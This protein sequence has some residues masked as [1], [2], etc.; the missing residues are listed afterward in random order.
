MARARTTI[1]DPDSAKVTIF[2]EA[3]PSVR[4]LM[5][6]YPQP[7]FG[8]SLSLEF[9]KTDGATH[10]LSEQAHN[11]VESGEASVEC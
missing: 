3:R 2:E 5:Y 7:I 4:F 9:P 1:V 8:Q 10:G 6:S 11:N